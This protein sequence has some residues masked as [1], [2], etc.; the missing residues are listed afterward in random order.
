M[1]QNFSSTTVEKDP[2]QSNP[3][4]QSHLRPAIKHKKGNEKDMSLLQRFRKRRRKWFKRGGKRILRALFRYLG[5]QSLVGDPPVFD[6]AKFPW[7]IELEKNYDVI[8]Q[9]LQGILAMREYIPFFHELSRDQKRI[10]TGEN[11]RTFFLKGFGYEA[12]QSWKRCPETMKILS[13]I[14]NLRNA[15]FS[16]LGPNYHIPHHRGVTK[17]LIRCHLGLIVPDQRDQCV[18]RVGDQICQWEEGRCFVF[19]DTYDH[20]VWNKTDQERVVL[21][22]DVDR[23]MRLIGR[24]ISQLLIFGVRRSRYVQDARKNLKTWEALY[25]QAESQQKVAAKSTQ[26]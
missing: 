10:S 8:R 24:L 20:E 12:E 23:P 5:K 1:N 26:T 17:G 19:D 25:D 3:L 2:P 21:L 16:I 18:M 13:N 4:H 15:L 14:P 9:E 11:W 6:T 22:I 7:A